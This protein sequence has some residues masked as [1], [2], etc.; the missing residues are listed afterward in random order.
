MLCKISSISLYEI[1]NTKILKYKNIECHFL[2][3]FNIIIEWYVLCSYITYACVSDT[4]FSR[5]DN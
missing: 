1:A 3:T 5:Q 2:N 4:C